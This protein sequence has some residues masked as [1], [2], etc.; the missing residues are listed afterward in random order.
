MPGKTLEHLSA[1]DSLPNFGHE[2]LMS[3][4]RTVDVVWMN[5]RNMPAAWYEV[6]MTTDMIR[7]LQKF[8]ELQD[9][10]AAMHIVA[11]KA[12]ERELHGKLKKDIFYDIRKRVNFQSTEKLMTIYQSM[13]A[14]GV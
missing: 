1:I 14:I 12:R 7:S 3:E 9:F 4:A 10:H 5:R 2:I 8:H 13:K 6:E 11:P